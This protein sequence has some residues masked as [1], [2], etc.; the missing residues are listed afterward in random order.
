M[1]RE[2]NLLKKE[3][4]TAAVCSFRLKRQK[5]NIRRRKRVSLYR[6]KT[7]GFNFLW[8]NYYFKKIKIFFLKKFI[9]FFFFEAPLM[10][11]PLFFRNAVKIFLNF[12]PINSFFYNFFFY[13]NLLNTQNFFFIMN[14]LVVPV[15]EKPTSILFKL[16]FLKFF[17]IRLKK[18]AILPIK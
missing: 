16:F 13:E 6:L 7:R 5:K 15:P 10:Q 8:A 1:I 11:P 17:F 18:I 3:D 4:I 9:K 14:K 12:T 2:H